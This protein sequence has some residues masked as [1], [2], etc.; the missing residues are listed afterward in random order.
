M[1]ERPPSPSL[2]YLTV[3]RVSGSLEWRPIGTNGYV[4]TWGAISGICP[5]KGC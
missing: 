5:S 1:R 2:V 4:G 3:H